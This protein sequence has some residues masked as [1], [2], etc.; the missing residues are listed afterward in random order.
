MTTQQDAIAWLLGTVGQHLDYD[1]AHGQQCV[2][3]FNFYYR[4]ITGRNPFDDGLR[5]PNID[6]A[7]QLWDFRVSNFAYIADSAT[8][9]PEPGDILI[10]GS[11]WGNGAGHVEVVLAVDESGCTVIGENE[12]GD[13]NQGVVQVHR[14]WAQMRGLLGV[15]RPQWAS[16]APP[17]PPYTI[18]NMEPKQ[19]QVKPGHY[20]WNLA[21][22]TFQDVCNNPIEKTPDNYTFTAVATLTRSDAGFQTYTYYLDDAN[23]PH[24]WNTLDC[25]DA[26]PPQPMPTPYVPPA[27]PVEAPKAKT[28]EVLTTLLT[29]DNSQ[30]A[31]F[32]ANAKGTVDKGTYYQFAEDGKCLQLGKDNQ[33][34][35]YW[36]NTSDNVV[37]VEPVVDVTPPAPDTT[38]L[39]KLFVPFLG[40]NGKSR[41]YISLGNYH[42]NDLAHVDPKGI[43]IHVG[44]PVPIYGSL[45]RDGVTYLI[46]RLAD[47]TIEG[48]IAPRDY[49]YG[50]PTNDVYT[51][52]PNMKSQQYINALKQAEEEN[53]IYR[54]SVHHE[55]TED[56][57]YYV[58]QLIARFVRD[59]GRVLN[60]IIPISKIKA[61][62]SQKDN[63]KR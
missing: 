13:Q 12:H 11:G 57:I 59:G 6:Y 61:M 42:I 36:I 47:D 52:L 32:H 7:R 62:Y 51:G 49:F 27:A 24:G 58:E 26:P 18:S 30:D 28:Y 5:S 14:T 20:K 43:D 22:P 48:Q 40:N 2:D 4:Q 21:L 29:F 53:R 9:K 63:K 39:H 1:N 31:Q 3:F 45:T 54:K 17:A 19:L 8:F 10:Y 23:T 34:P 50:I 35:L 37:K 55:T 46:P 15:M 38:D 25:Q 56:K 41:R 60:G 16:P 44:D 33:H